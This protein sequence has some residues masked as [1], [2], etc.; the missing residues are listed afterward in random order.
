MCCMN[1]IPAGA[2]AILTESRLPGFQR[3]AV[4]QPTLV[5]SGPDHLSIP[6]LSCLERVHND[7][8][9][10]L[11]FISDHACCSLVRSLRQL[12]A[13]PDLSASAKAVFTP[14]KRFVSCIRG[15]HLQCLQRFYL[16]SVLWLH[17]DRAELK[18]V[19]LTHGMYHSAHHDYAV[20]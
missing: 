10:T 15:T 2:A 18:A 11:H 16:P 17:N 8:F 9:L 12:T 20:Q 3:L 5:S 1:L 7:L 6:V 4:Q 13:N 19:H 14:E